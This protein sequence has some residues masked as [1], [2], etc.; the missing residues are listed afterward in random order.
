[1][2][3]GVFTTWV[4]LPNSSTSRWCVGQSITNIRYQVA[5]S[6]GGALVAVGTDAEGLDAGAAAGAAPVD[7]DP[8]ARVGETVLVSEEQYPLPVAGAGD[9]EHAF[10]VRRW[11]RPGQWQE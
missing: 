9:I 11:R 1:M 2:P 5:R 8:M 3:R 7:L 10:T 4:W 6:G